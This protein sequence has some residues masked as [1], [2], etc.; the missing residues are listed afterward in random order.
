M[1]EDDDLGFLLEQRFV[2]LRIYLHYW[3]CPVL[4]AYGSVKWVLLKNVYKC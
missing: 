1:I 4:P 2:F 3:L